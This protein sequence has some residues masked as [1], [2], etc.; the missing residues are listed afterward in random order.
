ME[1]DN[2]YQILTYLGREANTS[3]RKIAE[4]TGLSVGMVNI[5]MKKMVKKGLVKLERVNGKTLRYILTPK[6]M[7][8]KTK[9]AYTYMKNSYRQII[10]LHSILKDIVQKSGGKD[11]HTQILFYGPND[12]ILEILK[13][14]AHDLGLKY[15]GIQAEEELYHEDIE[16]TVI[17]T[18]N[19]ES[20]L[21]PPESCE[22][23]NIL[24]KL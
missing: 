23:I 5:L 9:L 20:N 11:N 17:V 21:L 15:I 22:V 24:E 12:E 18:W 19:T 7:T 14:A 4:G 2:Q 10:K 6:G 13:I 8:E 3:Q 16:N 1:V